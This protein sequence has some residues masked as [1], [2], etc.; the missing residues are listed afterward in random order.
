MDKTIK[1][2]IARTKLVSSCVGAGLMAGVSHVALA[3]VVLVDPADMGDWSFAS[4]TSGGALFTNPAISSG[5]MVTGPA[6]PPL[7]TGSANLV[8]GNGT[9]GGN[10]AEILSNTDYSGIALNSLTALSYSTYDSLNNGQQF[11]YLVLE[12][13]GYV[14]GTLT[15]DS[16]FFEPPY[17]T[18]ATGDPSLTPGEGPTAMNTWQTWNALA[19]AWWDNDGYCGTPPGGAGDVVSFSDCIS[20]FTSAVIVNEF[21]FGS[22]LYPAVLPG[23]G[24][25]QLEVGFAST[26]AI[27]NGNVDALTVGVSGVDT[28]Y[29]F[30]P[31]PTAVP[32]PGTLA[33]LG[34]GLLG[35]AAMRRRRRKS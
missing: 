18:P 34:T 26:S 8:T 30:D 25:L 33:L 29:N 17:Q 21:G 27:F 9:T 20:N 10:G 4:S 6:T 3:S 7:G 35:L 22:S 16:L 14:G 19:G 24:G 32:E 1:F 11:P 5:G 23:V 15:Y 31:N 12:I 13:A 28:T 2:G